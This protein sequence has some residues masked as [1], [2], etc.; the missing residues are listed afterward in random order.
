MLALSDGALARLVIAATRVPHKRRRAW[1]KRVARHADGSRQARYRQRRDAGLITVPIRLDPQEAEML[2]RSVGIY[3][4]DT[5][6][7]TL[8]QALEVLLSLWVDGSL[9]VARSRDSL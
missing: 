2:L 9:R 8:G 5:D 1:L 6:R 3:V 4:R 7:A